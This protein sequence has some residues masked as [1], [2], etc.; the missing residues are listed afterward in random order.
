MR[1]VLV[2]LNGVSKK[3]LVPQKGFKKEKKYV[4]AV[5]NVSLEIFKGETLSIVGES[6]CGKSTLG[7]VINKILDLKG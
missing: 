1:E 5:N 7:R 6:G 2:Q 3:F 4:H